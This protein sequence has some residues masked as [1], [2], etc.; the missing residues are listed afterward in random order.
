MALLAFE[1]GRC[2]VTRR[3]DVTIDVGAFGKGEALDRAASVLGDGPWMIDLGGQ[4]SVGGGLPPEGGWSV[5]IADPRRRDQPAL[6]V[7]MASGSLSTAPARN[8]TLS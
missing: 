4:I 2:T 8:E 5:A 7:R 6:H 3:A 1:Q